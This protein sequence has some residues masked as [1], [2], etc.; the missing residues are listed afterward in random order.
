MVLYHGSV[1][2]VEKPEIR[3]GNTFL[4]F[5]VGFYT[6]TSFAQAERWARI[7]MRRENLPSGYVSIYTFDEMAAQDN[8]CIKRFSSANLEWLLFVAENRRG[9]T[10]AETVD[11][12]IGPVADDNVYRTIRYFE[13]GVYD[14]EETVKRL[15]TEVLHDQVTFHTEKALGFCMYTGCLEIRSEES[16]DK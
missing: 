5:G 9:A 13:T 2:L 12:H 6:T 7:K 1:Y 14:A 15:K 4:D 11:M 10:A 3:L 16:Y 8:I